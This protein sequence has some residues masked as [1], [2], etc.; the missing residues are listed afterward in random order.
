MTETGAGGLVAVPNSSD[1]FSAWA[2]GDVILKIGSQFGYGS[3]R[4]MENDETGSWYDITF[5][6][7]APWTLNW[8][9]LVY[10]VDGTDFIIMSPYSNPDYALVFAYEGAINS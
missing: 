9:A 7:D 5:D 3:W 4:F 2:D 8:G 6:S 10:N 1:H